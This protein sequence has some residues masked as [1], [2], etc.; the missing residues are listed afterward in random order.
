ME[1]TY[2]N[3]DGWVSRAVL[4]I[5]SPKWIFRLTYDKTAPPCTLGLPHCLNRI[6]DLGRRVVP[7]LISSPKLVIESEALQIEA[8][9]IENPGSSI[10]PI[11]VGL[12]HGPHSCDILISSD[13]YDAINSMIFP[14]RIACQVAH[15][16]DDDLRLET[17]MIK[18]VSW[19]DV[20]DDPR[21][22]VDITFSPEDRDHFSYLPIESFHHESAFYDLYRYHNS[23]APFI[24][25][26]SSIYYGNLLCPM[27]IENYY[28]V[29]ITVDILTVMRTV[30]PGSSLYCIQ[31]ND[32]PGLVITNLID[33]GVEVR[34]QLNPLAPFDDNFADR[35]VLDCDPDPDSVNYYDNLF[36][37]RQP[38]GPFDVEDFNRFNT[39]MTY[40]LQLPYFSFTRIHLRDYMNGYIGHMLPS[41]SSNDGRVII[42]NR[43]IKSTLPLEYYYYRSVASLRNRLGYPLHRVPFVLRDRIRLKIFNCGFTIRIYPPDYYMNGGDYPQNSANYPR[44][45]ITYNNLRKYYRRAAIVLEPY[46]YDVTASIYNPRMSA[47]EC[48]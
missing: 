26:C 2:D 35:R 13:S 28:V 46:S 27:D 15:S 12:S 16:T 5:M 3:F 33:N 32:I 29:S 20:Q 7:K 24:S 11:I 30:L 48:N 17:S 8:L 43:D 22:P 37:T 44:V 45:L 18:K 1:N 42:C 41:A 19:N 38:F 39:M 47:D 40:F 4:S 14:D 23:I 25:R 6:M 21:P 36:R 9:L 34:C 10:V 31:G